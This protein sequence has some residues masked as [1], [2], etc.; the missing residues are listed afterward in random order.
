[1]EP[2]YRSIDDRTL[3][4]NCLRGIASAQKELYDRYQR[5]MMGICLRYAR[6]SD[7][8]YDLL[9]EGF[10]RVFNKLDQFGFE[11]SLEGWIRRIMVTNSINYL[12]KHKVHFNHISAEERSDFIPTAAN[13]DM[14]LLH[15]DVMKAIFELPLHYRT[16]INLYAIE[17]YSHREVADIL[18]QNESTCRSQYSRARTLL[19]KMLEEQ[20]I[21]HK[22]KM[23]QV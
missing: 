8:A 22:E 19:Q 13:N 3:V 16:V 4:Q 14:Q 1:L 18:G 20:Q 17:G 6:N 11:G 21:M 15:S 5:K 10:I 2:Q 23:S 7:D 9:Q 12:K